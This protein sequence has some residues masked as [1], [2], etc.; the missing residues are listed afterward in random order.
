MA[1]TKA[2]KNHRTSLR[3][4]KEDIKKWQDMFVVK[5]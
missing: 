4:S 2:N 1:I 3:D 5:K